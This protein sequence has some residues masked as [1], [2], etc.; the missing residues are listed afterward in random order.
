[1]DTQSH[2][3]NAQHERRKEDL[4]LKTLGT[5]LTSVESLRA[6]IKKLDE[7]Q[8]EQL[9]M[10]HSIQEV[11]EDI[12]SHVDREEGTWV[13]AFVDGDAESHRRLHEAMIKKEEA[14][15]EVWAIARK[16]MID[17][18]V[19]GVMAGLGILILY[20]WNGHMTTQAVQILPKIGG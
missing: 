17:M 6:E 15:A 3:E 2:K 16:K 10:R 8:L 12:Q 7:I 20:Y 18:T 19:Y 11:R 14:T 4:H 13:T 5:I 1:M 9:N